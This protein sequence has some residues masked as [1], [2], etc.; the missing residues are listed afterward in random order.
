M[1]EVKVFHSRRDSA[2][3]KSRSCFALINVATWREQASRGYEWL[4]PTLDVQAERS[5][6]RGYTLFQNELSEVVW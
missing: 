2:L 5:E 4:V 6:P 1:F 3:W